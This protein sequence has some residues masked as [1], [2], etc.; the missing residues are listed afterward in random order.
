MTR[1]TPKQ[2]P[3]ISQIARLRREAERN[4][5]DVLAGGPPNFMLLAA[6]M[7]AFR[8]RL[9]S[10]VAQYASQS[11]PPKAP[12]PKDPQAVAAMIDGDCDLAPAAHGLDLAY[13][14]IR[15]ALLAHPHRTNAGVKDQM[16]RFLTLADMHRSEMVRN[17]AAI[18]R[19]HVEG[20]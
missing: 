10:A 4:L 1:D 2:C 12:L 16:G 3:A 18:C 6:W 14:C 20:R 11:P 5:C 9:G 8:E 7:T 15:L 19:Q 17:V 13:T